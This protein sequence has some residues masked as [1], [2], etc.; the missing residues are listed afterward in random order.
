MRSLKPVIILLVFMGL[1][2]SM[3]YT[4]I[5]GI[6]AENEGGMDEETLLVDFYP[7][8]LVVRIK[9]I[10][11]NSK[12]TNGDP[13]RLTVDIQKVLKGSTKEVSLEAVWRPYPHDV[14]WVGEGSKEAMREWSMQPNLPPGMGTKWILSGRITAGNVFYVGPR[15]RYPYTDEKLEWVKTILQ[16]NKKRP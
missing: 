9:E 11:E 7:D 5:G 4:A 3:A 16:G 15:G 1:L 14:D 12:N 6:S 10:D 13:P 2:L 8:I